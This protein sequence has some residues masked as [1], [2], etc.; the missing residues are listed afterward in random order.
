MKIKYKK[1]IIMV[2][3][4]TMGIGLV[5]FSVSKPAANEATAVE[6]SDS[7]VAFNATDE[8]EAEANPEA[9][10]TAEVADAALTA[11]TQA[12]EVVVLK[13]AKKDIN[14]LITK[15]LSAKISGKAEDFKTL[16]NDSKLL[17]IEDIQ[18]KTKYIEAYENV[19]SYVV[20]G[21]TED[22]Y[23]V[24]AYHEVK[25]SGI[26]TLAPAMNEFYVTLSQEGKPQI[27]L[28]EIDSE[29][30]EYLNGVRNSVEV[31]DVIYNVNDALEKAVKEDVALAEFYLKLEE[32]TKDVTM[33][34]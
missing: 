22:S 8:S 9:A 13:D 24:Y 28:G 21:P 16:V 2:T 34:E 4:C 29:T 7:M 32:S 11:E 18:R 31:M 26:D 6:D 30:A 20:E 3:M 14:T 12:P 5:T 25:F 23:I 10:K 15:Y 17:D 1:M 33:N 19:K 27:Y